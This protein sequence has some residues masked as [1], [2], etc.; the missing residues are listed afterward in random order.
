M[1]NCLTISRRE[2]PPEE[3]T[4]VGV[5]CLRRRQG[6]GGQGVIRGAE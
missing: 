3:M 4:K 2:H 6:F 1:E 5:D